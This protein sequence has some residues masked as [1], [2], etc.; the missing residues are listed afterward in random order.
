VALYYAFSIEPVVATDASADVVLTTSARVDTATGQYVGYFD[1]LG[2]TI[3]SF[4]DISDDAR[5]CVA[6]DWRFDLEASVWTRQFERQRLASVLEAGGATVTLSQLK[7]AAISGDGNWIIGSGVLDEEGNVVAF[8]AR[9][10]FGYP[11]DS[12]DFNSDGSIFD[13]LDVDAFFSVFSEGPCIPA[14]AT[15]GDV[16]FNNDGSQFDVVDIEAFLSV[17]AEGPCL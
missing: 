9:L 4:V 14:E 12:I 10:P 2:S 17:F 7:V 1:N 3:F 5:I 15:C 13:P 11:C 16:D 8:R 6:A